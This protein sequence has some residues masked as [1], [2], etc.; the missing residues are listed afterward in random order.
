M[1]DDTYDLGL[2]GRG[3]KPDLMNIYELG[4]LKQVLKEKNLSI[5]YL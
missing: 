4:L 3:N 5:Q 2:I 1:A